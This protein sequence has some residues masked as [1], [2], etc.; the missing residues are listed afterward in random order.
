MSKVEAL[1]VQVE[2]D[3]Y[4]QTARWEHLDRAHEEVIEVEDALD[5]RVAA[6]VKVGFSERT[7]IQM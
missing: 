5:V 6:G 3:R 4:V 2:G 7:H 1:P